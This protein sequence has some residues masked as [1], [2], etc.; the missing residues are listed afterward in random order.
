MRG[1]RNCVSR[2]TRTRLA[3]SGSA[4]ATL[5]ASWRQPWKGATGGSLVE[6]TEELPVR[7]RVGDDTRGDLAEIASLPLLPPAGGTG[8][9]SFEGV[10]LSA[11]TDIRL[12]P[13]KGEINRRNGERTNTVQAF[14]QYGVLPEE[15]LKKLQQR[16]D[17]TGFELPQ[18]IPH[19]DRRRFR[20]ARRHA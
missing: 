15:A 3:W 20:R 8:R 5:R 14:V 2:S 19:R 9:A 18:G 12:A 7:V 16:L 10:P 1:R 11:I 6:G 17:E 13:S 4:L